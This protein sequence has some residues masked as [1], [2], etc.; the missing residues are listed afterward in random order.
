MYG[1]FS[2]S[3][4]NSRKLN[5]RFGSKTSI[6]IKKLT[7]TISRPQRHCKK[8]SKTFLK[9]KK[10]MRNGE[11][12]MNAIRTSSSEAILPFFASM[13]SVVHHIDMNGGAK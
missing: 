10:A 13:R 12:G 8:Q 5:I 4:M 1:D 2:I 6:T 7:T 9:Q 11:N 3:K